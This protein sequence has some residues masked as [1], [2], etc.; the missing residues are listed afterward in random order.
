ME[1]CRICDSPI[2]YDELKYCCPRC[3]DIAEEVSNRIYEQNK[4]YRE[5]MGIKEE[6]LSKI[7]ID[8]G[9]EHNRPKTDRCLA[10]AKKRQ[11]EQVKIHMSKQRE[12]GKLKR[13]PCRHCKG[14]LGPEIPIQS[15]FCSN[16]CKAKHHGTTVDKIAKVPN[17]KQKPVDEKWLRR[18]KIS[19]SSSSP[20]GSL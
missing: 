13:K 14:E 2:D 5:V 10:C 4:Q 19:Y 16:E 12:S 18:G 11:N 9:I 6:E 7:C 15:R 1:R 8:C 3:A 17:N 20:M